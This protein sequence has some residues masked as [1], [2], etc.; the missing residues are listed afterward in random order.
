MKML[1]RSMVVNAD[2]NILRSKISTTRY[3]RTASS[4]QRGK[5]CSKLNRIGQRV[6]FYAVSDLHGHLEGLD[7]SGV[8]AVLIAGDFSVMT[9]WGATHMAYQLFW[10]QDAFCKWCV[11]Y[12]KTMFFVVPGNHDLFAGREELRATIKWPRNVK[13]LVDEVCEFKGRSIYGAPWVPFINGSWAFE[14]VFPGHL[15]ERFASIPNNLDILITHSPP[16]IRHKK[17][18]VSMDTNSPH[19]G[20]A[21]LTDAIMRARPRFAFCGHIH[22]GDHNPVTID[23]AD[24]S[25]TL[26]RN[27]SRLDEEYKVRY[28]PYIF[29]L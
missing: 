4:C 3:L 21:D 14:E 27:V 17:V 9:G 25:M 11:S 7:P 20:S 1:K 24:G 18:D 13:L 8:D 15:R 10:V 5:V 6:K 28:E 29:E 12:P 19:F 16:I 22:T 23:H 2:A 26:L